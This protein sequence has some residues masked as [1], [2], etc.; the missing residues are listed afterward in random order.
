[1][2]FC[3]VHNSYCTFILKSL[4]SY[5][6]FTKSFSLSWFENFTS[7]KLFMPWTKEEHQRLSNRTLGVV[8]ENAAPA[9]QLPQASQ[10][11]FSAFCCLH[12][13]FVLTRLYVSMLANCF[14]CFPLFAHSDCA[15][16]CF[17]FIALLVT[18]GFRFR[19]YTR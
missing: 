15:I 19:I 18:L 7:F 1:M 11:F 8:E 14:F 2:H 17:R 5:C 6:S 3:F 10:I 16:C 12:W 4:N 13:R 9:T